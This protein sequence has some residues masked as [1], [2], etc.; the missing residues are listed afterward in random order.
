METAHSD[1][2]QMIVFNQEDACAVE[3]HDSFKLLKHLVEH[4]LWIEGRTDRPCDFLQGGGQLPPVLFRTEEMGI[5]HGD[6]GLVSDGCRQGKV[7]FAELVRLWA[8]ERQHTDDT[9]SREQ[10]YAECG[11]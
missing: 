6:P 11:A 10:R 8:D 2:A 4:N 9:V 7:L 1:R 5:A 3:M